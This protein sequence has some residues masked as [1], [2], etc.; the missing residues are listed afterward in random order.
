MNDEIKKRKKKKP[1][2]KIIFST[3]VT[4]KFDY[5]FRLEALKKKLTMEELLELYQQSY[6]EKHEREKAERSKKE[7]EQ[8]AKEN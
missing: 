3:R 4:K 2:E 5:T 8:K 7:K 6:H 1:T